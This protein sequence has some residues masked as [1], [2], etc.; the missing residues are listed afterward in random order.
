MRLRLAG[1]AVALT[2]AVGCTTSVGAATA[3][4]SSRPAGHASGRH[5]AKHFRGVPTVGALFI[6]GLYPALHTCTASVVRSRHGNVI[7]T[8]AHCISG[9]GAYGDPAWI[10]RQD[11]H[12]DWA[13][14][15]VAA[16]RIGGKVR[17]L[18]SITGGHP[19]GYAARRRDRVTVVGYAVGHNDEPLRCSTTVYRHAGYPAFNCGGFVDGTSGSPWLRR[20]RTGPVVVGDIGGL[21]QGGCTPATSYSP[22]LGVPAHRALRR[23]ERASRPDLFPVPKSDGC[24]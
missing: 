20:S 15:T 9:R 21:H 2:T 7:M 14:L 13:F 4:A 17:S 12:R 24:G 5:A 8:A 10:S 3:R 6:P 11:P 1:A 16:R 23:A 18:Q 22:P 19:L